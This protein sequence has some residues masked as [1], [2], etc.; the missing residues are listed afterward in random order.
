MVILDPV[1]NPLLVSMESLYLKL[2]LRIVAHVACRCFR[3]ER[4]ARGSWAQSLDHSFMN[5]M[6]A[7]GSSIILMQSA[8]SRQH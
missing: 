4:V 3:V 6:N 7:E 5:T 8:C 1:E 2:W